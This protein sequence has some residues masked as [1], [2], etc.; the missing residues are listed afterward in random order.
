MLTHV[1]G[2]VNAST[3]SALLHYSLHLLLVTTALLMWMPIIGPF[4]ELHLSYGGK[5]IYLFGQ[6]IV[7]TVPAGWLTF[8]ERAV[9]KH[10]DIPVRVWGIDVINDQ[11]IAGGIMKTG[12]TIFIWTVIVYMFFKRFAVAEGQPSTRFHTGKPKSEREP[13]QSQRKVR[14]ATAGM[15]AAQAVRISHDV[16]GRTP[17]PASASRNTSVNAPDGSALATVETA[18]GNSPNGITIPPSNSNTR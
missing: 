8:A 4:K 10:Y 15:T 3:Q 13:A 2:I 12:G 7:P 14:A 18:P 17:D 1:P 16:P 11:Q 5:M 9:Y 6:S